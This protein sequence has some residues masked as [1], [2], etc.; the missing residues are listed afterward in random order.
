MTMVQRDGPPEIYVHAE[1]VRGHRGRLMVI[2]V[3]LTVP[4]TIERTR[5]DY[6]LLLNCGT[7][8]FNIGSLD[9]AR[10]LHAEL[11]KQIDSW[12]GMVDSG[13]VIFK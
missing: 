10:K 2:E 12:Q 7:Q 9:G 4:D 8:T 1:E 5:C 3:K 13:S 11:G 6:D